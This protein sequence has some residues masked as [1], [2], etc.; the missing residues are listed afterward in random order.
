M[1]P[2]KDTALLFPLKLKENQSQQK[3]PYS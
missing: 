2:A 3:T 1:Q